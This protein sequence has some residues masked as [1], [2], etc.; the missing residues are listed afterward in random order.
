MGKTLN[1]TAYAGNG[2]SRVSGVRGYDADGAEIKTTWNAETGVAAFASVP[3]TVSYV[4]DTGLRDET[5]DV[6]LSLNGEPVNPGGG[7]SGSGGGC[8]VGFGFGGLTLLG[9]AALCAMK[10]R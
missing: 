7:S 3:A 1:L 2:L 8:G 5:M 10:R 9:L 4:Y 6:T